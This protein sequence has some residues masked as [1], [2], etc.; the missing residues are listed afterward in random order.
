MNNCRTEYGSQVLAERASILIEKSWD[1]FV[2]SSIRHPAEV[3]IL[4][5][6]YV[7]THM[8]VCMYVYIYIVCVSIDFLALFFWFIKI[9]TFSVGLGDCTY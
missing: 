5:Q 8:Y 2:I 9:S 3:Q 1:N 7:H 6:G 4:K